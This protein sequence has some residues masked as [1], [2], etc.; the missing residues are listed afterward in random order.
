MKCARKS[1]VQEKICQTDM[2]GMQ[3]TLAWHAD[4]KAVLHSQ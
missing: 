2:Q 3:A 4:D 1:L